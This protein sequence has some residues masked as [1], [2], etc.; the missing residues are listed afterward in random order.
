MFGS[1]EQNHLATKKRKDSEVVCPKCYFTFWPLA[2]LDPADLSALRMNPQCPQCDHSFTR[3]QSVR[4]E[5][6]ENKFGPFERPV[7]SRIQ[8]GE[9]NGTRFYKIP[10]HE[11]WLPTHIFIIAANILTL[12]WLAYVLVTVPRGLGDWSR[13]FGPV[14]VLFVLLNIL[15]HYLRAVYTTHELTLGPRTLLLRRSYIRQQDYSV[16]TTDINGV[17]RVLTSSGDS[18]VDREY[19]IEITA[20]WDRIKFSCPVSDADQNWLC[21]NIREFVHQ[22]GAPL[23][24]PVMNKSSHGPG[25][26]VPGDDQQPATLGSRPGARIERLM[27]NGKLIYRIPRGRCAITL[28]GVAAC[29]L[30]F[31]AFLVGSFVIS[32]TPPPR[33]VLLQAS[34]FIIIFGGIGIGLLHHVLV[35]G[36]ATHELVLGSRTTR[37]RRKLIFVKESKVSTKAITRVWSYETLQNKG[38]PT[39]GLKIDAGK[40]TLKIET[41]LSVDERRWLAEDIRNYARQFGAEVEAAEEA[42]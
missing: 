34:P 12:G 31:P 11:I 1:F 13:L 15:L 23:A 36:F 42:R 37:V 18:K 27:E 21:W 3:E 10:G 8:V 25:D 6:E 7:D 16:P 17:R 39:N 38:E 41:G 26:A 28:F 29:F 35:H 5:D 30:V 33:Q 24:L 4:V 32:D 40:R 2:D 14:I 19:G 20:G 9:K 22:H